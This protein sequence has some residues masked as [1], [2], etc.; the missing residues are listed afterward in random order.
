[1]RT[2][3]YGAAKLLMVLATCALALGAA[4]A[5]ASSTTNSISD[6]FT[7]ASSSFTWAEAVDPD[8]STTNSPGVPC[9]T[10]G[11]PSTTSSTSIPYCTDAEASSSTN[12]GGYNGTLTYSTPDSAG[13]GALR[14]TDASGNETAAI[15][16]ATPFAASGG[17]QATFT[18]Y[19]Y[20]GTSSP[21]DG[22][23]FFILD[24]AQYTEAAPASA[25]PTVSY[26]VSSIGS[27]VQMGNAGG[28]LGYACSNNKT[29]Y[30]AGVIGGYL[31]LGMDEYG[32]F[33]NGGIGGGSDNSALGMSTSG[34]LSNTGSGTQS[35]RMGLRGQGNMTWSWL[36]Y[37][38]P[39]WYPST[40]SSALSSSGNFGSSG[41]TEQQKAV[42][43]TCANGMLQNW[44]NGSSSLGSTIPMTAFLKS[45][46]VT[47]SSVT[48]AQ[49]T[50]ASLTFAN[51]PDSTIPT[52][53]YPGPWGWSIPSSCSSVSASCGILSEATVPTAA[54]TFS[55][56]TYYPS[57]L[58]ATHCQ[59]LAVAAAQTSNAV[60]QNWS[61]CTSSNY[62]T[63]SVSSVSSP[64]IPD[65]APIL[66]S[67]TTV[68]S[69]PFNSS[70]SP[71]KLSQSSTK[72]SATNPIAWKLVLTSSGLLSV[73]YSYNGSAYNTA[74]SQLNIT[75]GNGNLPTNLLFG[76]GGSTGGSN[77]IHEITCFQVIP[78]EESASSASA[79]GQQTGQIKTSTTVYLA[80][81][82]TTNP[83]TSNDGWWGSLTANALV[84]NATT[85]VITINNTALWDASC[86]LTGATLMYNG[87]CTSTGLGTPAVT[88]PSS[89]VILTSTGVGVGGGLAFEWPSDSNDSNSAAT[90]T[91]TSAQQTALG[92]ASGVLDYL[93]GDRSKEGTATGNY[94]TRFAVL[95][96]IV[97]SSPVFVSPPDLPYTG[98]WSDFINKSATM[99]ENLVSTNYST[100]ESNNASRLNVV[101]VGANDGM[102]HAFEAGNASAT[103]AST[104]NYNDGQEI[105]AYVPAAVIT[106]INS[107]STA[108]NN[109]PNQSYGHN[110]YVDSSPGVGDLVYNG[111]WVSWLVGG[112]GVGGN[113]AGDSTPI[114]STNSAIY[115]LDITNPGTGASAGNFSEATPTNVVVGEWNS[116]T[117]VSGGS[118]PNC[119]TAAANS[120]GTYL[121][122]VMGTPSIRRLHD[123][124]WGA[125]FG[126]GLQSKNGNAGLF[127]MEAP[128]GVSG[129]S[130][131][132]IT[133]RYIDTGT[134][135]SN[136][137]A[138]VTPSDL[139]ADGIVDYVY[140][141]DLS[142]NMWRFDLTS[143]TA[144][145]WGV[146]N[147]TSTTGAT[148][149]GHPL[150]T[151]P[152][153]QPITSA[154]VVALVQSTTGN[155]RVIVA[156]GTGELTSVQT[157][158]SPATYV[159]GTQAMYGIWDWDMNAWNNLGSTPLQY[160]TTYATTTGTSS[161]QAQTI[162]SA[163][164][165]TDRTVTSLSVCWS[166]SAGCT[167]SSAKLGWYINLP[168]TNEQIIYD[169]IYA[170]GEFV[171]NT[172]IPPSATTC[173]PSTPTGYTMAVSISSGGGGT[174]FTGISSSQVVNGLPNNAVGSPQLLLVGTQNVLVSQGTG[175]TGSN[176]TD[177]NP[178]SSGSIGYR[179]N[180][181]Q[182]R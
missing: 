175:G 168:G 70:T 11:T 60:V 44:S 88:A 92:G 62:K 130:I 82:Y 169:G 74:F 80:G 162:G 63:Y 119:Y 179:A 41:Y 144:S 48:Y 125:I 132:A 104:S 20:G 135:G 15:I 105:M 1:M 30:V 114:A 93:R 79:N 25:V 43:D 66:S 160:L 123:G 146:T 145:N 55:G 153:G 78:A 54:Y 29:P 163:T 171:V 53:D 21:A 97:D 177:V 142:G 159:T 24:A 151:T 4:P 83:K 81:Y 39:D 147:Y 133:F 115:A 134:S 72:R 128:S 14:L 182:I 22:F 3:N 65:Y 120:C 75:S 173:S 170:Y 16:T 158:N 181:T 87:N 152:S 9:L 176:V 156:F 10:A 86:D 76:F 124:N 58:D 117:I 155:P 113:S 12:K 37:Y 31:A 28:S 50:A 42:Y 129:D 139:D 96:D 121:G 61:G 13:Q 167:G 108:A 38:Y 178:P 8:A 149:T 91:I 68:A 23:S 33:P 131:S 95:G 49:L 141:G 102:L 118:T 7:G 18:S 36:S 138:Q 157:N 34:V 172:T 84:T 94:R 164:V 57:G 59:G 27:N 150:Y 6:N 40:G 174:F 47:A 111:K 103:N 136:G 137:I 161:L 56:S 51:A 64:F 166:G 100:F 165:G 107:S 19:S 69:Y 140:G 90:T 106:T 5:W 99:E 45:T 122:N 77:A 26:A 52:G 71:T 35:N 101:Y 143:S 46:G 110:F 154:P 109:F 17:L 2:K 32:N 89:R 98:T 73:S 67:G 116:S 126:N 85:G 112:L 180:W 127:V 148:G